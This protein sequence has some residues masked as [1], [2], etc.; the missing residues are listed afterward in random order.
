M[1]QDEKKLKELYEKAA[2]TGAL[3]QAK[4]IYQK[5]HKHSK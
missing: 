1:S 2:R 5:I 4:A 3:E